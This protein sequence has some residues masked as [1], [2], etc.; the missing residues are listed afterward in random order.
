MGRKKGKNGFAALLLCC[1]GLCWAVQLEGGLNRYACIYGIFISECECVH[2]GGPVSANTSGSLGGETRQW[3]AE[4]L[5]GGGGWS[6]NRA[7]WLGM[8]QAVGRT[9]LQVCL[10]WPPLRLSTM[11]RVTVAQIC[12]PTVES[13]E[14]PMNL[15]VSILPLHIVPSPPTAQPFA[16]TLARW[17]FSACLEEGR[18]PSKHCLTSHDVLL[19]EM[20]FGGAPSLSALTQHAHTCLRPAQTCAS[21]CTIF[22]TRCASLHS[23]IGALFHIINSTYIPTELAILG[24]G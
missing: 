24:K 12:D 15:S 17:R 22:A 16:G 20:G 23:S 14:S 10:V 21:I 2:V 13:P 4:V 1:A 5:L 7:E 18:C 3:A 19:I 11:R 6:A 9:G 8:L